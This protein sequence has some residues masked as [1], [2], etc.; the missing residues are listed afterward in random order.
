M[1]ISYKISHLNRVSCVSIC[2]IAPDF[3]ACANEKRSVEKN[4]NIAPLLCVVDLFLDSRAFRGRKRAYHANISGAN[5][6]VNLR[7]YLRVRV[8]ERVYHAVIQKA[9]MISQM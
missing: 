6:F 2:F 4:A 5:D 1:P 8:G 3:I 7:F 9:T